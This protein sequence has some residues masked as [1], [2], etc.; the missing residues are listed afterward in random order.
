M[1]SLWYFFS[2]DQSLLVTEAFAVNCVSKIPCISNRCVL[3]LNTVHLLNSYERKISSRDSN[4]GQ[5]GEKRKR[6]LCAIAGPKCSTKA[7]FGHIC[8]A[9][10]E[11]EPRSNKCFFSFL[12]HRPIW[13]PVAA[14][15]GRTV[16]NI[17]WKKPIHLPIHNHRLHFFLC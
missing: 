13:A 3:S 14:L 4:L 8:A 17:S 9:P 2:F 16:W 7:N 12:S 6:Y 10:Q 5:L 1:T 15:V 11:N